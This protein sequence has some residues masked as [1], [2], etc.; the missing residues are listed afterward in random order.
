MISA[1][2]TQAGTAA[3]TAEEVPEQGKRGPLVSALAA[4]K[5]ELSGELQ[6]S[7]FKNS[8]NKPEQS[9]VNGKSYWN[10]MK[11]TVDA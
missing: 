8:G 10:Q 1:P 7:W 4:A 3:F 5:L 11:A 9:S 2:P 6:T